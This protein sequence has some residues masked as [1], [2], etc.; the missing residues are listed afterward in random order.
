M[1]G[2]AASFVPDGLKQL[3][4]GSHEYVISKVKRAVEEARGR[5][6]EAAPEIVA[7]FARHA[8]IEVDGRYH[9]VTLEQGKDGSFSA[10]LTEP[11]EIEAIGPNDVGDF[12]RA[13]AGAVAENLINGRPA[14]AE[15]A[16]RDLLSHVQPRNPSEDEAVA[17][18]FVQRVR[19]PRPWKTVLENSSTL[20]DKMVPAHDRWADIE[21]KFEQLRDP[22]RLGEK[23]DQ[24]R[25]LVRSSIK[26]ALSSLDRLAQDL[27]KAMPNLPVAIEKANQHDAG[28]VVESFESFV[29][30]LAEDLDSI[31]GVVGSALRDMQETRGLAVIHD[32]LAEEYATVQLAT[33]F[34]E[35]VL[36]K[37]V[38]S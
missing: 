30:D 29:Q 18:A 25:D 13:K 19:S 38:E 27:A 15:D 9:R 2:A 21:P 7:T 11:L 31:R 12:L 1:R 3:T 10:V 8:I 6:F 37:F 24:Y 16:I 35:R 14:A 32:A 22:K 33:R 5:L 36:A 26:E 17:D 34:V 28:E 4:Q 23:A 20:V